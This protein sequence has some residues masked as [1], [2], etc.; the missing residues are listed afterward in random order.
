MTTKQ[1]LETKIGDT[2][3]D[4]TSKK[5]VIVNNDLLIKI[6]RRPLSFN[7]PVK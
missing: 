2:V 3:I 5:A 1:A 7:I 4:R 6:R